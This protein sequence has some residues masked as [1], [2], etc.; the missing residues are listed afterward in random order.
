MALRYISDALDLMQAIASPDVH[1]LLDIQQR[2]TEGAAI[3]TTGV[4]HWV[5]VP[6]GEL[7]RYVEQTVRPDLGIYP[8]GDQTEMAET[9]NEDITGA[10]IHLLGKGREPTGL[11]YCYYILGDALTFRAYPLSE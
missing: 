7:Y 6:S 8:V 4:V 2:L 11:L 9:F 5:E 3:V 1:Q 10:E